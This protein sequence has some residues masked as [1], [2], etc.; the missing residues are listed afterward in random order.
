[1]TLFAFIGGCVTDRDRAPQ[2]QVGTIE[3]KQTPRDSFLTFDAVV[4][5]AGESRRL[6][7]VIDTGAEV[8]GILSESGAGLTPTGIAV[9]VIGLHGGRLDGKVVRSLL[10]SPGGGNLFG[11]D[12]PVGAEMVVLPPG[13]RLPGRTEALLGID[14]L[15]T[16]SSFLDIAERTLGAKGQS[17]PARRT[18]FGFSADLLRSSSVGSEL[19]FVTCEYRG[20]QLV[21]LL[22]T[23]ASQTLLSQ[24]TAEKIGALGT[25]KI[26][27]LVDSGGHR[28]A[29]RHSVV[30]DTRW[31]S[32]G[33][34]LG[35]LPVGITELP[36][37]RNFRLADGSPIDGVIGID[38]LTRRAEWID[39]QS[40]TL[41]LN[42]A[43]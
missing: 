33:R 34:N 40:D 4:G 2:G 36:H 20:T 23:G 42:F 8:S 13:A 25:G 17:P 6:S 1:M 9:P 10:R 3:I 35:I 37:L 21:W 30:R 31:G 24:K 15:T 39:F 5:E 19:L 41:W 38:M 7:F 43:Q 14:F 26:S 32:P 29:L 12:Q 22:D 16:N 28:V 27:H 11:D 18:G